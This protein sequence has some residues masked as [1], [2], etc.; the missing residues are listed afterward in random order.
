MNIYEHPLY[1]KDVKQ[2][3]ELKFPWEKL[4][5]TTVVISGATG[6]LGSFLIDV[7]MWRNLYF[8]QKCRVI[9]VGRDEQKAQARFLYC[10]RLPYFTFIS[11]DINVPLVLDSA[12][13]I[14]YVLH[15]ASNTHPIAYANDPIGTITTNII[16][17]KNML[18]FSVQHHTRRFAFA[19]SNEIYGENRGDQEFFDEAYCG[20]IDCNTLRAGYPESKRCG[21]ALCQA[22]L[23]QKSLDIVI[24]RF[25][26]SYGP[27]MLK[28]DSKAVSQ[29]IKRAV[30]GEDIVLKSEGNQYYSY[31]YVS[32][33]ISGFLT[34]LLLGK[35]GEAYNIASRESDI[36]LKDLAAILAK[37]A[38]TN[39]VFELPNEVEKI[40]YSKATKARLN[41]KKIKTLGWNPQYDIVTGLKKTVILLQA[42]KNTD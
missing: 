39:V 21:E 13:N 11:H 31:T 12:G 34:V 42:R 14:D 8:E 1:I 32:D 18:D 5:N 16:G 30:E 38:N 41:G 33:A 19:S 10:Y 40:G 6:L 28:N 23:K 29:F 27:T 9:A 7:L 3:A 35:T 20:Y 2:V 24:P 15:L 17:L 37:I 4:E 25:T 36:R 22:Y 26:R